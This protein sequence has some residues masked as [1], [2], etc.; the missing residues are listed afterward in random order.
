MK[1]TNILFAVLL[2]VTVLFGAVV[3]ANAASADVHIE[4]EATTMDEVSVT[5]PTKLPIVFRAD[6]TNTLPTNWTIENVSAIAGIHLSQIDMNA[7]ETDWKLLPESAVI[8]ELAA[9]T[10]AIRFFVGE[11]NA[12]KMV[13][14]KDKVTNT[15][16]TITFDKSE[17]SIPSGG[18]QI[19]S[20][21]VERGAFTEDA[22]SAEAFEMILTFEFN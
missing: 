16:G 5:V 2:S 11:E 19:L 22:A 18:E 21:D 12:L 6:G 9:D 4:I 20:F 14:P 10:K 17:I 8:S 15:T 7:G 3:P 1:K 13:V